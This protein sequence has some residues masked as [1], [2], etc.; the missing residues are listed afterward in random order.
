M[1]EPPKSS[2]AEEMGGGEEGAEKWGEVSKKL[3]CLGRWGSPVVEEWGP[4]SQCLGFFKTQLLDLQLSVWFFPPPPP[5]PT[6]TPF[7]GTHTYQPMGETKA[8]W[9]PSCT[10]S[11]GGAGQRGEGWSSRGP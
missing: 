6:H 11:G 4:Q 8:S 5:P 2:Q 1:G 3:R 10:P 7:F 9:D